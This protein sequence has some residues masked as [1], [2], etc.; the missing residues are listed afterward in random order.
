VICASCGGREAVADPCPACNRTPFLDGRYRLDRLLGRGPNGL[1]FRATRVED[2]QPRVARLLN[3]HTGAIALGLELFDQIGH[4]L[5]AIRHPGVARHV[6]H[7]L[8]RFTRVPYA[9][10]VWEFVPGRD[11]Q[12][13]HKDAPLVGDALLDCLGEVLTTLDHLHSRT[14]PVHHLAVRPRNLVRCSEGGRLVLVDFGG[15]ADAL[16]DPVACAQERDGFPGFRR[17]DRLPGAQADLDGLARTALFL[18]TGSAPPALL[19]DPEPWTWA[20]GS[21]LEPPVLAF[22]QRMM[23][24]GRPTGAAE[25]YAA[26]QDLRWHR[27]VG[28]DRPRKGLG[29]MAR[30]VLRALKPGSRTEES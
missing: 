29:G 1:T 18:A 27:K 20:V 28:A 16:Q 15:F 19:Q 6:D 8:T 11:L 30:Q 10:V 13:E 14:P 21:R 9:C 2:G 23:G 5:E 25:L 26:V 4:D 17:G 22:L 24:I 3:L 7:F 12:E